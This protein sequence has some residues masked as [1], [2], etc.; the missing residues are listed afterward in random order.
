MR[1]ILFRGKSMDNNKWVTGLLAR[2]NPKF[3]CANIVDR[4][5]ILVPV[6][7]ETVGQY[8]GLNDKNGTKIFEGD[9][10]E[11][12][13]NSKDLVK[14]VFGEFDVVEVDTLRNIDTVSGW[15]YEVIPTDTL[16]KCEP[17]NISMPLADFYIVSC[18]MQIIGNICDNPE[19]LEESK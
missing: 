13:G 14:V 15:H 3:A 4:L 6:N 17:F 19:L 9:I 2:Y 11:C 8:T 1:E 18:D 12:N 10:L 16:S 7:A 5:E